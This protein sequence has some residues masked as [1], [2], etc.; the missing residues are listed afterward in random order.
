MQCHSCK[1]MMRGSPKPAAS[2]PPRWWSVITTIIIIAASRFEWDRDTTGITTITITTI[3]IVDIETKHWASDPD[4][5]SFCE[6][7][8]LIAFHQQLVQPPQPRSSTMVH[9]R[10]NWRRP[11][12]VL[13]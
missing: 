1:P 12:Q 3:I 11:T 6:R 5:Q 4:A 7:A 13:G 8:D 9:L 10:L 2:G